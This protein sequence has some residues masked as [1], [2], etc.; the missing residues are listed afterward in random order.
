MELVLTAKT[1][2]QLPDSPK[3]LF[4]QPPFI[5]LAG[6]QESA[7]KIVPLSLLYL[8]SALREKEKCDIKMLD[9]ECDGLSFDQIDDYLVKEKPHLVCIACLTPGIGYV[10]EIVKRARKLLP[11]TIFIA[12]GLH[13][14]A[15]PRE[16]ITEIGFDIAAI[17]EAEETLVELV[18]ALKHGKPLD[19]ILGISYRDGNDA[20]V[21]PLRPLIEN[22]DNIPF[23]ARD[24]IDP[25]KYYLTP[26]KKISG[27]KASFLIM[28]SRGCVYDCIHCI[29][30]SVW[31]QRVRYRSAKN[32]V[33]EIEH[34]VKTYGAKEFTF[35][36]DL[37]TIQPIRVM[38]I[39]REIIS[40]KLD[41]SWICLG[42]TDCVQPQML[43]LMKDAGC[44]KIST[45]I[46][47]GSPII[48]KNI[49]KE[50]DSIKL[51]RG[52]K[53]IKDAGIQIHSSFM[54]GS[55]GETEG[56]IRETI[57]LAKSLPLDEA[58]FFITSP[59]PGTDLYDLALKNG[60]IDNVD[61]T[62]FAPLT[63]KM[64]AMVQ[65]DLSAETL[66]KWQ[67]QAYKE[68]YM[69]PSYIIG[70]LRRIKSFND[71]RAGSCGLVSERLKS[72]GA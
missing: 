27:A 62:Q 60:Y 56:T 43:K 58:T 11:G 54:I 18:S 68:F 3:I 63:D 30:K 35:A 55:P 7:G 29:S 45:G 67:K 13:P 47:S 14:T 4:L 19:G 44:V 61:W 37:F 17:G 31:R 34:C 50:L 16:I 1:H 69:R 65:G 15:F 2:W 46:E 42:R 6:V 8:A 48:L 28:S 39:C 57:D 72:R 12:G 41:I 53:M 66:I 64:P 49:R 32:F 26:T 71:V 10:K 22:L 51:Q 20:G 33:D 23:P 70:K 36:D 25:N 40:R 24:L 59:Y 5:N 38:D 9:A 21:T 52:I